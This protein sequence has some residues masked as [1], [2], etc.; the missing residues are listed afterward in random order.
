LQDGSPETRVIE[1]NHIL[2]AIY[3][4]ISNAFC[5]QLNHILDKTK[6]EPAQYISI[7]FQKAKLLAPKERS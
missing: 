6:T 5:I 2:F 1:L 3:I 4:E 7:C